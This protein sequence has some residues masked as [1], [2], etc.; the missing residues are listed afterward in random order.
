MHDLRHGDDPVDDLA[1]T[2][3]TLSGHLGVSN[4]A[5]QHFLPLR[6][7]VNLLQAERVNKHIS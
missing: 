6:S 1:L 5:V 7:L 3:L 2:E 4:L